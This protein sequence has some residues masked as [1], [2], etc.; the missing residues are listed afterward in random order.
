[1]TMFTFRIGDNGSINNPDMALMFGKPR[2]DIVCRYGS[3][4]E[5][6]DC[7]RSSNVNIETKGHILCVASGL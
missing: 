1:M 2:R 7:V 6:Q 3:Q 5:R 4:M